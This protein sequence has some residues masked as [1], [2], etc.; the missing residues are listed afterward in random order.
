MEEPERI[1]EF[2]RG[3]LE[4]LRSSIPPNLDPTD[5]VNYLE[6]RGI[7]DELFQYF[8]RQQEQ[9]EEKPA[10]TVPTSFDPTAANVPVGPP[11]A[12]LRI[13][14]CRGFLDFVNPQAAATLRWHVFF[15]RTRG[16]TRSTP[17]CVDPVFSESFVLP[18]PVEPHN[19]LATALRQ[20]CP[21]ALVLVKENGGLPRELLATYALDWREVLCDA[22]FPVCAE[23]PGVGVSCFAMLATSWRFRASC[24]FKS[25]HRQRSSI[26]E[27]IGICIITSMILVQV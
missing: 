11:E 5:A 4:P 9:Q 7:V 23:L 3:H 15:G 27:E 20:A 6:S 10:P 8:E 16:R 12:M 19:S 13:T 18:L 22:S 2:L 26:F 17:A 21:L 1:R 25:A 14:T 24:T